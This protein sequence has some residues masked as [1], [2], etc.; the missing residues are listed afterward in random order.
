MSCLVLNTTSANSNLVEIFEPFY[1]IAFLHFG[2]LNWILLKT[3]LDT[4]AIQ[5]VTQQRMNKTGFLHFAF[6][7]KLGAFDLKLK[8]F[9]SSRTN[10]KQRRLVMQ[11]SQIK[12]IAPH[13]L[14]AYRMCGFSAFQNFFHTH[15]GF[16]NL[17]RTFCFQVKSFKNNHQIHE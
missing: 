11:D 5:K 6:I 2:I 13:H 15:R 8:I 12:K 4:Q 10:F 9:Y 3:L 14:N 1:N 17:I 16:I 7:C